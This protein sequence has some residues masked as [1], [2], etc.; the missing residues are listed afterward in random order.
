M[1]I[2]SLY[3]RGSTSTAIYV[4][5][6]PSATKKTKQLSGSLLPYPMLDFPL[7]SPSDKFMKKKKAAKERGCMSV[8]AVARE[9]DK[10]CCRSE[11]RF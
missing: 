6:K 5:A 1:S 8:V 11:T 7:P 2:L 9:M 10:V 4:L 3:P